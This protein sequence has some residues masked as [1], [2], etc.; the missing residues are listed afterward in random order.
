M[1]KHGAKGRRAVAKMGWAA[2]WR[3]CPLLM[4]YTVTTEL[5]STTASLS[6]EAETSRQRTAT[7]CLTSLTGKGLSMKMRKTCPSSSP[8]ARPSRPGGPP[9]TFRYRI[10]ESS[11]HSRSRAPVK[12]YSCSF[13][14][15]QRRKCFAVSTSRLQSTASRRRS[16][17]R[18]FISPSSNGR[19]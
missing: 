12:P 13:F 19:S 2:R 18:K 6:R 7:E 1:R 17:G 9:V 8:T 10:T 11:A 14:S 5:S 16:R 4:S 15:L 3:A